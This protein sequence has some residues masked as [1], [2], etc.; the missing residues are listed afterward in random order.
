[1]ESY[2]FRY[3]FEKLPCPSAIAEI[4]IGEG[5]GLTPNI[6]QAI[7]EIYTDQDS[8]CHIGLMCKVLYVWNTIANVLILC[9]CVRFHRIYLYKT[10]ICWH[11]LIVCISKFVQ[12]ILP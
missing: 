12:R 6:L 8:W 11:D 10:L 7:I 1:M 2:I 3:N 5:N 9:V 4:I